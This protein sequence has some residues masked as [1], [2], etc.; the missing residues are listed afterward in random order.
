MAA[1]ATHP[2]K[3]RGRAREERGTALAE[4]ALVMPILLLLL[5]GMLDFGK[6][7]HDWMN[8]THLANEGARL[9][10]VNYCPNPSSDGSGNLTCDWATKTG[11]SDANANI[12]LAQYIDNQTSGELKSGR[13]VNSYAP[14]QNAA[15][16][17]ISYP[18]GSTTQVGD[19][20]KVTLRVR[21]QWLNYLT[22]RLS[23]AST[24]LSGEAIMRLESKPFSGIPLG[25]ES[26]YPNSPAGT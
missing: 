5:L 6:A 21:Y 19:P 24:E 12:C 26:C 2:N 20:V 25:S 4:L 22:K 3:R 18:N 13:A 1:R 9:A 8:Q 11:C 14:A 16:V 10:A 17:C 15:R 23:I 7:F